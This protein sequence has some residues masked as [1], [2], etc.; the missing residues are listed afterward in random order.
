[1]MILGDMRELGEASADAHAEVLR[2]AKT[3][4][5]EEIWL[6]GENFAAASQVVSFPSALRIR[7]FA[8]VEAVEQELLNH[9]ISEH[10][11]LIKGSNGTRLFRLPEFL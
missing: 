5:C 2:Q 8:D 10:L 9:P 11:I 4:G 1:M 7:T 6:V 3:C